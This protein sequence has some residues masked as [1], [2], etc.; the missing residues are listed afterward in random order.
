MSLSKHHQVLQMWK[1]RPYYG[2]PSQPVLGL[3][4]RNHVRAKGTCVIRILEAYAVLAICVPIL[5]A[6]WFGGQDER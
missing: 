2:A 3:F 4:R 1:G 6:L 5:W